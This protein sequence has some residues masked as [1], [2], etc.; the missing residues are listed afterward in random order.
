MISIIFLE[1]TGSKGIFF[2]NSIW[3]TDVTYY[4]NW[5]YMKTLWQI[6]FETCSFWGKIKGL[7]HIIDIFKDDI[8]TYSHLKKLCY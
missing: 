4:E 2:V 7:V 3:L 8:F 1:Q 5:S 6:C